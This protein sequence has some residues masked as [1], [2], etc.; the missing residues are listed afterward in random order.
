MSK[1]FRRDGKRILAP[2]HLNHNRLLSGPKELPKFFD[3]LSE[4]FRDN[5]AVPYPPGELCADAS[6]SVALV[7]E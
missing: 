3:A 4:T 7:Q 1:M 5:D 6:S 2:M